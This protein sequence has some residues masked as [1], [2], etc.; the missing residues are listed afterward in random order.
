MYMKWFSNSRSGRKRLVRF[1]I[2]TGAVTLA[3]FVILFLQIALDYLDDDVRHYQPKPGFEIFLNSLQFILML[4]LEVIRFYA[5]GFG[6]R[7]QGP[8][9]LAIY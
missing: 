6:F 7:L 3:L 2:I 4:P 8:E 5:T 9:V 1:I